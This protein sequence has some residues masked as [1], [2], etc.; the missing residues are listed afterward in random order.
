MDDNKLDKKVDTLTEAITSNTKFTDD[1]AQAVSTRIDARL[2]IHGVKL[3]RVESR[4]SRIE[5]RLDF[6]MD[7]LR[8]IKTTL[9]KDTPQSHPPN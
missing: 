5:H 9:E 4:G 3:D 7:D 2:D 8:V 6:I 1:F